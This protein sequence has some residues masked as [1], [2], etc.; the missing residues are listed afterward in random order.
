MG[1]YIFACHLT[2]NPIQERQE[3]MNNTVLR[4]D[5]TARAL[6]VSRATIWNW[7]NPKSRHF[8]PDFPKPIKLSENITGWLS[9][10]IEEY[11][12]KLAAKREEQAI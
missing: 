5:D 6:G 1:G 9:S 4:A 3:D 2:S 10:E 8:R 7:A 12:N 11:L